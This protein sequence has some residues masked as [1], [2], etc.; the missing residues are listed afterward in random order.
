MKQITNEEVQLLVQNGYIKNTRRGY[1]NE[2]GFSVGFTC[3]RGKKYI[4]EKYANIAENLLRNEVDH[5]Q[6]K[7]KE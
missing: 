3:T 1:I 2:R 7:T 4:E 5:E 6:E